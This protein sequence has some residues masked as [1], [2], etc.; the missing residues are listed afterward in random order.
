MPEKTLLAFADH[1][2]SARTL[3]GHDVSM[4]AIWPSLLAHG[5]SLEHVTAQLERDGVRAFE[6][7]YERLLA[8]IDARAAEI[9][10]PRLSAA[11]QA[12]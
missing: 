7:S 3:K 9:A 12:A 8:A 11:P 4:A 1:G 6:N 2:D 10:Q 5:I